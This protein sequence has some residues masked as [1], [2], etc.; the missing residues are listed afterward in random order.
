MTAKLTIPKIQKMKPNGEKIAAITC[1]DYSFARLMDPSGIDLVLVGDSLGMVIQGQKNTI[2]VSL[3]EVAYHSACVARGLTRPLLVADMPFMS[4]Q[5]SQRQAL[6]N[7]GKLMKKGQAESV[8]LEGG[9]EAAELI[10]RMD[11]VGIPVMGHIGLQ[12]QSVHKYGGYKVQGKSSGEERKL[13]EDAR[14]VEQAGAWGVVLEGMPMEVAE[15]ITRQLKIPTV[16]IGSGPHCDGQ[17][18]VIYDLLGMDPEFNP[19]FLKR[20]AELG[21]LIPAALTDYSRE[22]KSGA[23][24]TEANAFHRNLVDASDRFNT[25]NKKAG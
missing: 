18:L 14:A 7:A 16:G 12:P 4:Y 25:G 11:R 23:F 8:K 9:V 22:V 1:Y 19:K 20:Y 6:E 17:I 5:A 15:K 24:P 13:M 21:R 3:N 10:Y 2:P